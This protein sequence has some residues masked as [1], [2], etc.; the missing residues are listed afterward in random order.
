[1]PPPSTK[2]T[3]R[4]AEDGGTSPLLYSLSVWLMNSTKERG[5]LFIVLLAPPSQR[6]KQRKDSQKNLDSVSSRP[7]K[8]IDGGAPSSLAGTARA[9]ARQWQGGL[10]PLSLSSALRDL[11]SGFCFSARCGWAL[12]SLSGHTP[13]RTI[14]TNMVAGSAGIPLPVLAGLPSEDGRDPPSL[15]GGAPTFFIV[16]ISS[17]R[18]ACAPA[19]R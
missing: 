18:L 1:M 5:K 13:L 9:G 2:L 10:S 3:A 11:S 19:C 6:A 14:D 8:N 15:G 12:R 7:P 4:P 16:P 17:V